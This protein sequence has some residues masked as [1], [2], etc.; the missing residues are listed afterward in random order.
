MQLTQV[1]LWQVNLVQIRVHGTLHGMVGNFAASDESPGSSTRTSRS[2]WLMALIFSFFL[3][4]VRAVVRFGD[5]FCLITAVGL[6]CSTLAPTGP[7]VV[8]LNGHFRLLRFLQEPLHPR[9]QP[10]PILHL[11]EDKARHQTGLVGNGPGSR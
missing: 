11:E 3:S 2:N 8:V 10:D 7:T 6:A 5:D 4:M 9:K 1:Q